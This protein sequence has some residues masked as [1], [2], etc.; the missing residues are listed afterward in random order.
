MPRNNF[1][2]DCHSQYLENFGGRRVAA[3]G[4]VA[5]WKFHSLQ[6]PMLTNMKQS[7]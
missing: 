6:G 5:F 7:S 1:C 2:E 3:V 4:G